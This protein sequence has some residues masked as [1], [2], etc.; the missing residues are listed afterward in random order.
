MNHS[1]FNSYDAFDFDD[2]TPVFA[3]QVAAAV[4]A[5]EESN[6]QGRR[7]GYRGSILGHNIVNRNRK[8]DLT[9]EYL[10]IGESTAIE[11]LRAFVKAIVEV[12]GD[13]YLRA[14]NEA[15][16]CRLLSIGEQR[17]FSGMLRSIDCMHWKWEKCPIAWHEIYTG[18]CHEPTIILEAVASQ[19]L[20]IWHAF[21]GMPGSLNDINVLDR[22]PIFAALAE[23]RTPPVNYTINGHEYTMGYYLA[24]EI[25]PNLSTFVKTI[26]RPLGAK[27]KYFAS[28]QES[29]RKD[30]E[31]AFGVLQSRFAIVR[32]PVRYWDEE[33]LA[34]IMKACIIMHNMII[35]DEG[36]MNLGF[37]HEREVNS[38]DRATSSQLQEDLVEYLWEQY[39]NE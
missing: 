14:P 1:N 35:E 16:V 33:T 34:N 24:D 8:E 31:R 7:T 32:G 12:F 9:D 38:L 27:R 18:H 37:D 23:G 20:W 4:V 19:D 25:Y 28:K 39:G 2:D 10:Q 21:F 17:G 15:D 3:F 13:S 5:E 30:V 22:S 6:N 11:S 36:A 29:A 26:P